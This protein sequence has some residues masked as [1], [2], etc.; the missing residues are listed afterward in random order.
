MNSLDHASAGRGE[1]IARVPDRAPRLT[2]T[3]VI[4]V[5]AG[6]TWTAAAAYAAS[7]F[8]LATLGQDVEL[9]FAD[10]VMADAASWRF[11]GQPIYGTLAVGYAG[12]PYAPGMPL[13]VGVLM[14]IRLWSGWPLLVTYACGLALIPLSMFALRGTS[15]VTA[16]ARRNVAALTTALAPAHLVAVPLVVPLSLL[17]EGRADLMSWV[18]AMLAVVIAD[19]AAGAADRAAGAAGAAGV[20]AGLGFAFKQTAGIAIVAVVVAGLWRRGPAFRQ[21]LPFL[22]GAGAVGVAV[23][24]GVMLNSGQVGVHAL[25]FDGPVFDRAIGWA[26]ALAALVV[27]VGPAVLAWVV[28]QAIVRRAVGVAAWRAGL[29][30]HAA[31]IALAVVGMPAA[32]A[33]LRFDGSDS[34]QMIGIAL[35]WTWSMARTARTAAAASAHGAA[36]SVVCMLG[37]AVFISPPWQRAAQTILSGFDRTEPISAGTVFRRVSPATTTDLARFA[38]PD[39]VALVCGQ[40]AARWSEASFYDARKPYRDAVRTGRIVP[41][42]IGLVDGYAIGRG[43]A[44]PLLAAIRGRHFACIVEPELLDRPTWLEYIGERDATSFAELGDA[45]R[46]AYEPSGRQFEGRSIW[47]PR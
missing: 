23:V 5:A 25:L 22:V 37:L 47:W 32:A 18:L 10:A 26:P 3:I 13:L 40:E 7:A 30:E 31:V 42:I 14:G 21:L 43:P 17:H 33:L 20:A 27:F 41:G 4:L 6:I 12:P 11:A 45:V 36:A 1:K 38:Q 29:R 44:T 15:P 28:S 16:S 34:N 9:G 46:E 24:G 35:A 39:A 8:E 2:S 19:R